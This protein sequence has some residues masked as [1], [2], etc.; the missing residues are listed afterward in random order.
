M[1][2]DTCPG[3]GI[4]K[5]SPG[6]SFWIDK[7][8]RILLKNKNMLDFST[9]NEQIRSKVIWWKMTGSHLMSHR[10]T[11]VLLNLAVVLILGW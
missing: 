10:Y 9:E 4:L 3:Q 6:P 7:K 5:P 1:I 11:M 8:I 2:S